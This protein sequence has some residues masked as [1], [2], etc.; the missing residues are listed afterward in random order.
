MLSDLGARTSD[1]DLRGLETGITDL[2]IV[3]GVPLHDCNM[4]SELD[5]SVE[6]SLTD[7]FFGADRTD[8]QAG[9]FLRHIEIYQVKAMCSTRCC[10][11][12]WRMTRE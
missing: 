10:G 6:A 4:M 1:T 3:P 9:Y 5:E 12:S 2:K 11:P 7:L 8:S